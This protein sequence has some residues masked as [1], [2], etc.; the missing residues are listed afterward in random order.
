MSLVTRLRSWLIALVALVA[1]T[2]P[3]LGNPVGNPVTTEQVTARLLAESQSARPGESLW[4]ML[5]LEIR[6]GWHTYWR[7]P[8]DSGEPPRL[9][10]TLPQGVTA[11]EIH[12]PYP[13]A[14]PTGPLMSYGYEGEAAHLVEIAVPE[15]WPAGTPLPLRAEA[16]WLVCAEIC[17][18]ES[19]SLALTLPTSQGPPPADPAVAALFAETRQALPVTM[20]W[21]IRF[22]Q[23]EKRLVLSLDTPAATAGTIAEAHFFPDAWGQVEHA[24]PQRLTTS[25]AGISLAMTAGPASD[26]GQGSVS[27]VLV[28]TEAL[29]D[30]PVTRA[31]AVAAPL[32]AAPPANPGPAPFGL[33]LVSGVGLGLIEALL[34]ALLGGLILNLMPC[35]L[36]VLSMKA[37]ALV[38]QADEAPRERRLHGLAYTAGI[39]LCFAGLATLL[40]ALKAAGQQIGWGFQL[41]SPL[42]VALMAYLLFL[43]GLSLSGL[44]TFGSSLMG[45]GSGLAGRSGPTGSFFTGILAALVATPCTAPFMGAAMGFALTQPWSVALGVFLALGLGLALP[46][47]L[48]TFVPG[49]ARLL[50]RPGAWME[51]L[52]QFLAFPLYASAAWLVWVL[53]KQVGPD[54][55]AAVLGGGLLIAFA[56]WL[57]RTT[58]Q[59]GGAA[60]WSARAGSLVALV[61]ALALAAMP[62]SLQPNGRLADQ[63]ATQRQASLPYE[64]FSAARL[65]ELRAAG[66]PVFVNFTAA[67]C[68]PCLVNERVALSSDRI[69]DEFERRG[70][71]YLK[72][73]W[74][75]RDPEI[76]ALLDSFQRS[77]VPLYLLYPRGPGAPRVLP[78][79]LTEALMI[80]TL[81]A[82]PSHAGTATILNPERRS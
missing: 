34:F 3:A 47:L 55:V 1:A 51:R 56:L 79:L 66:Q 39:L 60:R 68:I 23:D 20:P 9:D 27:G 49:L 30:G 75:N 46:Y 2:V 14:V 43:L 4:V 37:L 11:S 18:P 29:A 74:T 72:G 73:D 57:Y 35:V 67:W 64:D 71:V 12:W 65:A 59:S 28:L 53:G 41:Q 31:F 50:P 44:V 76:T 63:A 26:A 77:G 80:E 38:R 25:P 48:L 22:S 42:F 36:P 21:P 10:W 7:N 19:G 17:I 78:Q 6:E 15:N 81:E 52:K 33:E 45:L 16:T 8:G 13:R 82:L 40:I 58:R 62:G 70:I 69:R 24:A 5:H 54:G 32:G 61:A